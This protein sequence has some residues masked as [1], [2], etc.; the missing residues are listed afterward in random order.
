VDEFFCSVIF[1]VPSSMFS[2]RH[3][4]YSLNIIYVESMCNPFVL[5]SIN[6]SF[7]IFCIFVGC[8]VRGIVGQMCK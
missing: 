5:V 6:R 3:T 7:I 4:A 1:F 2:L 8:E